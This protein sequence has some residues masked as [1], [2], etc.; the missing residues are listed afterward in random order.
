MCLNER[1]HG[2]PLEGWRLQ[3]MLLHSHD[4]VEV[5][6]VVW[7]PEAAAALLQLPQAGVC[8]HG[9]SRDLRARHMLVVMAAW[10]TWHSAVCG[11]P[12]VGLLV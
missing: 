5:L 7:Q 4:Q 8:G 3:Q 1:S 10:D 9:S 12:S 11:V 2:A 6:P